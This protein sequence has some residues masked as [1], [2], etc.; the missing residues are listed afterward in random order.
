MGSLASPEQITFH[1]ALPYLYLQCSTQVKDRCG[2][3]GNVLTLTLNIDPTLFAP[4]LY[5]D[6]PHLASQLPV[7][8]VRFECHR[9]DGVLAILRRCTLVTVIKKYTHTLSV[10]A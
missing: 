4:T 1:D 3:V 10:D 8:S 2:W 7:R 5:S 9:L 6:C